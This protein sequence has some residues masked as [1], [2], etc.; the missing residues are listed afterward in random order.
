MKNV[1]WIVPFL[2]F[3]L[4]CTKQK[5][6]KE[7][8]K[9]QLIDLFMQESGEYALAYLD[10]DTYDSI[11]I[12]ATESYHAA[13]TM[14]TPVMIEAYFQVEEGL[15]D[16]S[17]SI[18]I[19]NQFFSIVDSSVYVLSVEDDSEIELYQQVG[20]LKTMNDLIYDMIIVSSNLATNLVIEKVG[21]N[22][23][24][25]RMRKF[26]ASTI[27]VLRGVEDGKAYAA[28]LSNTT[29]A[30]DLMKIY[31]A[32]GESKLISSAACKAMLNILEDQRFNE[33]IPKYLP[34]EVRVAHKTGSITALHHDSGLVML[35]NGE[36][37][38]LI[39]LSS[40][41]LDFDKGTEQLALASKIIFDYHQNK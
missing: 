41:L 27:E 20:T 34:S 6:P 29:S 31:Q 1:I 33:M 11:L 32:L 28:G 17:D 14:K 25:N 3:I 38:V 12:N 30:Y 18:L 13:S 15:L 24:T 35:P 8:V 10:L 37:Y 7:E 4:S 9:Q 21:A 22:K 39:L 23:T 40:D 2:V 5:N 19:K 36:K 16:L 26:G